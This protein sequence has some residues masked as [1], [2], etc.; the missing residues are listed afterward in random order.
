[1]RRR[2]PALALFVAE[3][4]ASTL[5]A[6]HSIASGSRAVPTVLAALDEAGLTVVSVT[7]AR[8]TLDEVYLR[9]AGRRLD[10]AA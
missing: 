6:E 1:M 4:H 8:P 7:V 10:L 9:H 3:Y 2:D 5:D